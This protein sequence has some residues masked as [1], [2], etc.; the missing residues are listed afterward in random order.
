MDR[1]EVPN[2]HSFILFLISNVQSP[3]QQDFSKVYTF[4][5]LVPL[6]LVSAI[7]H[8]LF[9]VFGLDSDISVENWRE[10][11]PPSQ[12]LLSAIYQ[13][14]S[15]PRLLIGR[16]V[17]LVIPLQP[18]YYES[19][20]MDESLPS[21][22]LPLTA[23]AVLIGAFSFLGIILNIVPLIMLCQINSLP[24][25]TVI[26]NNLLLL[27][28]TFLNVCLWPQDDFASWWNGVGLC[29]V[30]ATLRTP[31][32]TLLATSVC[33]LTRDL[34]RAVDVEHPRLFESPSQRRRRHM[35]DALCIFALPI[36]QVPLHYVVQYNRYSI[37]ATY[38][39][40]DLLDDSW[41]RVVL[42]SMWPLLVGFLNV[43]YSCKPSIRF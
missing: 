14:T 29:D 7:L 17:Q 10:I 42:L 25:I 31:T 28:W 33:V 18:P 26:A 16:R 13:A 8:P 30:Q 20:K 6:N 21:I 32:Y 36:L 5:H 23:N 37:M 41:P 2:L 11:G 43:Y 3:P 35:I 24:A 40:V 4:P 38:G 15:S 39:C 34:S 27:L 19:A 22:T 12:D 1:I 9:P